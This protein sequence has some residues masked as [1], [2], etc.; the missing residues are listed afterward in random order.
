MQNASPAANYLDSAIKLFRYYKSLGDKS[1]TQ[2]T[3]ADINYKPEPESNSIAVIVQHL[4]GNMLSR[5]TDFL[6]TDGEKVWRKRDEEIEESINN[7]EDQKAKWEEGWQVLF[8][9]LEGLKEEDA[10]SIVYIR[11]QGHTVIEAVNRQLG[12]YAYHI[13]QIVYLA[14][15][16]RSVNWQTLSVAKGKTKEFNKEMF[17]KEK[18][19][20]TSYDTDK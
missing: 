10:T 15:A 6:T 13:G 7:L 19:R 20:G 3:N 16:V 12:H 1:F 17:G 14:K 11:N 18:H 8:T 2:L 5:F 9:A 4:H